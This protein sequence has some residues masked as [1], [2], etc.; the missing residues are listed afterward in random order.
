[1]SLER[2]AEIEIFA[3]GI[4][5]EIGLLDFRVPKC[6]KEAGRFVGQECTPFPVATIPGLEKTVHTLSAVLAPVM[7]PYIV[8]HRDMPVAR[9]EA[10]ESLILFGSQHRV[11]GPAGDEVFHF[12]QRCR[13]DSFR[14]HRHAEFVATIE[15]P[16]R[17]F[18][19]TALSPICEM[20]NPVGSPMNQA[21][22][23]I[24]A[25]SGV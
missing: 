17:V 16:L 21:D 19:P 25:I 5:A 10:N 14:L 24:A 8:R 2:E 4:S 9:R 20:K 22:R 1:M 11:N 6:W 18:L 12:A 3:N 15:R 7:I 13:A 23:N